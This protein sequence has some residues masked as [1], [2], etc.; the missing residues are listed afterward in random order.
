MQDKSVNVDGLEKVIKHM[1]ATT[2]QVLGMKVVVDKIGP[3]QL[4][5]AVHSNY[6]QMADSEVEVVETVL[7]HAQM[8]SHVQSMMMTQIMYLESH[9]HTWQ[10]NQSGDI[11]RNESW[12]PT[13]GKVLS[14]TSLN[15]D[16]GR[17]ATSGAVWGEDKPKELSRD[18]KGKGKV[19]DT[20]LSRKRV[21]IQKKKVG[22]NEFELKIAVEAAQKKIDELINGQG[23][24]NGLFK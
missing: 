17:V 1:Q 2:E 19:A 5:K 7:G 15:L 8:E 10:W 23:G 14:H 3:V 18:R 21:V 24:V 12:S 11:L 6:M 4:E 22:D 13:F 16:A 20:G 9:L